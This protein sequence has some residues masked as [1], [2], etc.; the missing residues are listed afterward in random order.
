M[1]GH[2]VAK[3]REAGVPTPVSE[4]VVDIVR[5]IDAGTR[6]P[7]PATIDETLRRAGIRV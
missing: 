6:E 3:G 5:G 4:I 7:A 1:N 2:V